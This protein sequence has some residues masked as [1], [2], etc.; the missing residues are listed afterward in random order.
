MSSLY[1]IIYKTFKT[2]YVNYNYRVSVYNSEPKEKIKKK[3]NK[4]N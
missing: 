2:N 1:I 3:Q 4:K